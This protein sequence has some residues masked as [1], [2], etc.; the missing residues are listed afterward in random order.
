M[1]MNVLSL[2]HAFL[3]QIG[4]FSSKTATRS[5]LE[6][7]TTHS[8]KQNPSHKIQSSITFLCGK[9]LV[10]PQQVLYIMFLLLKMFAC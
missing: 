3:F 8:C 5:L 6:F 1:V 7:S 4:D 10:S 2:V 9:T